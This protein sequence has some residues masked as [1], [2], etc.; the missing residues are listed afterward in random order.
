MET[1]EFEIC[2]KCEESPGIIKCE[3]DSKFCQ[4][5]YDTKHLP[6]HPEHQIGGT[7]HTDSTWSWISGK[8]INWANKAKLFKDD[9]TAK[10]FGLQIEVK[11][12]SGLEEYRI[13]RLVETARFTRLVEES[14]HHNDNSPRR[15]FP[16]VTSF[17]GDTGTGKSTLGG[18]ICR[19]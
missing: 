2:E 8:L 14:I 4:K 18:F 17:I 5:C 15:Q 7:A 3:C 6:R 16:S 9:E 19:S 1:E 13:G 11:E 10:W 12:K